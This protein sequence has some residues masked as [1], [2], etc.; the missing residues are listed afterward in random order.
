VLAEVARRLDPHV[1]APLR[2][3]GTEP[4]ADPVTDHRLEED[5]EVRAALG[6][7]GALLYLPLGDGRDRFLDLRVLAEGLEHLEELQVLA[8]LAV[9]TH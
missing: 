7:A 8:P 1:G 3:D 9:L 4:L 2:R 6:R 5:R